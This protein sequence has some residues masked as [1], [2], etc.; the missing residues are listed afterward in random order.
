M[1]VN[2][3]LRNTAMPDYWQAFGIEMA[4]ATG[5]TLALTASILLIVLIRS[6]I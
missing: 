4:F 1:A 6:D 2:Y 5:G 3:L